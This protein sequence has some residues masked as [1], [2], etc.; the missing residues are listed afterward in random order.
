MESLGL[1]KPS[2]AILLVAVAGTLYHLLAGHLH[3]MVWWIIVGVFGTGVFQGLCRGGL[4]PVAWVLMAIPILIVCFFLAV[5]LFASRMRIDNVRKVPCD[6]CNQPHRERGE[7][8]PRP[9]YP[10]CNK[11]RPCACH[12]CSLE[13]VE[14]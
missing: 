11:P 2:T 5:A 14:E 3:G 6:R 7:E 10:R 12:S 1:C 4:E 13:R 8:C 9:A